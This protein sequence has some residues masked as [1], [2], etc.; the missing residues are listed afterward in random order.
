M[1]SKTEHNHFEKMHDIIL[2]RGPITKEELILESDL[3]IAW[4]EKIIK[5]LP[6]RYNDIRY[7]KKKRVYIPLSTLSELEKE[8]VK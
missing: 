3:S 4:G 5:Y 1:V 2:K 8:I 7:D 6:M